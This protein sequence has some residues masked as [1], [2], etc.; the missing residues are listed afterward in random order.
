[1]ACLS[2]R[3]VSHRSGG[4]A[5]RK[6]VF[7]NRAKTKLIV[8]LYTLVAFLWIVVSDVLLA[9]V[10]PGAYQFAEMSLIKGLLY[11]LATAGLLALLLIRIG[12]AEERRFRA[13]FDRNATAMV[14]FEPETG[15]VWDFNPAAEGLFAISTQ[16]PGG[17]AQTTLAARGVV[18]ALAQSGQAATISGMVGD[19]V[20]E[21]DALVVSTPVF[22]G[23]RALQ[24]AVIVNSQMM[25][26]LMESERRFRQVIDQAPMAMMVHAEDGEILALNRA[27]SEGSGYDPKDLRSVQEWV[28]LAHGD[29]ADAVL[30]SVGR[31]FDLAHRTPEREMPIRRKDGDERIWR[32]SAIGLGPWSDGRRVAVAMATD[33]TDARANEEILRNRE[34]FFRAITEQT[35]IGVYVTDGRKLLYAN[36]WLAELFGYAPGEPHGRPITDFIQR[37]DHSIALE[38]LRGRMEGTISEARYT[39]V[40]LT[41][42]G[43]ELLLGVHGRVAEINGERVIIGVLQDITAQKEAE[44]DVRRYLAQLE[45]MLQD[46]AS[47]IARIAEMRDPYTS[48]HENR[49]GDLSAAIAAEMGL[50]ESVQRGLRIAGSLHDLGKIAIPAEILTKPGKISVEEYRV[51][52]RH[53]ALGYQVLSP[54]KFPWPVA[55]VAHQHHERL[56]G[57]GYPQGLKGDA[58]CLEARIVAVA[59]V[60]EALSSHR[61]Y[62]P[63]L[64]VEAALSE[65]SKNRGRY[66]DPDVVDACLR[67]VVD[68]NYP[69][70]DVRKAG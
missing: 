56:D 42:D 24:S 51:I 43:R 28:R 45:T 52:Q 46:T 13:F 37:G 17:K 22:L 38:S 2:G 34:A 70:L 64:G 6:G 49:V 12:R 65:I 5:L 62:R 33:V 27:W 23:R 67:L 25:G 54:I 53:P 47:A 8:G 19:R 58:I 48:G 15:V 61:P 9:I 18:L 40:G 21:Q 44:Q 41:K 55:D 36:P 68:K 32:F 7:L 10:E 50:D 60:V 63:S 14:L 30:Q 66:Y 20:V 69:L 11:V 57:S 29:R 35:L 1:M 59:D 26:P 39:A 31:T 4:T 16:R 3:E